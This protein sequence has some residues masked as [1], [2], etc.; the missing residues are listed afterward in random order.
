MN[1]VRRL[2]LRKG[3]KHISIQTYGI[4][5]ILLLVHNKIKEQHLKTI[6]QEVRGKSRTSLWFIVVEFN[7][8]LPRQTGIEQA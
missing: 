4:T 7:N 1:T 3:G 5:G 2:V 8:L 6:I